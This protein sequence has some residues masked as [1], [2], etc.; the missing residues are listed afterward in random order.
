MPA[1]IASASL[2]RSA[3]RGSV[4]SDATRG[5]PLLAAASRLSYLWTTT[6]GRRPT[7]L[8]DASCLRDEAFEQRLGDNSPGC[9]FEVGQR[10]VW[11]EVEIYGRVSELHVE[12]E[13]ADRP[14]GAR[15]QKDRRVDREA[16]R[17][18]AAFRVG[19][20]D[21]PASIRSCGCACRA[22]QQ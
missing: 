22:P 19:E 21:H 7:T 2:M 13:Q 10:L 17:A 11:M 4:G 5:R 15:G 1:T 18:D 16:R 9:G 8:T 20:K 6:S 12:V 3:T 14:G